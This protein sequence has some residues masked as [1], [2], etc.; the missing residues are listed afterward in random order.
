[1]LTVCYFRRPY[2]DGVLF[3]TLHCYLFVICTLELLDLK[4]METLHSVLFISCHSAVNSGSPVSSGQRRSHAQ[5]VRHCQ[6]QYQCPC[7][8]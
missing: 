6:R 1:M 4:F 3:S 8:Y 2:V 7:V 5:S